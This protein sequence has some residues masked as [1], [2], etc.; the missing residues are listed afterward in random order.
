[1]AMSTRA[2]GPLPPVEQVRPGLWS[3]PVPIP[4]NPL[5]YVLVYVF[6]T[7]RG[8][9]MVDAGWNTDGLS[10]RAASR[11]DRNQSAF[12]RD[13]VEFRAGGFRKQQVHHD[14]R[15]ERDEQQQ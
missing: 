8:P 13:I 11:S 9:F 7:D 12:R 14:G 2:L 6:E 10:G 4:N 5:R 1:M 3:V 15:G